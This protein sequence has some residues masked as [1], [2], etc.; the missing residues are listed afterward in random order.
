MDYPLL[1][2]DFLDG[3]IVNPVP[4]KTAAAMG[5]DKVIAVR[6]GR[7]RPTTDSGAEARDASGRVPS[8]I[9]AMVRSVEL[10]QTTMR[11]ERSTTT[12]TIEPHCEDVST[13][14]LRRFSLGRRYIEAGEAAVEAAVPRIAAA[15][16][17][18]R[19]DRA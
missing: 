6:L 18:V 13:I 12:I 8:A 7:L 4:G 10:M 2:I 5:A 14:G 11:T 15:L 17:W 3:G 1:R 16:P 9:E 19:A